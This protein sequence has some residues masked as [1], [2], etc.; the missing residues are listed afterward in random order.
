[1]SHFS[2]YLFQIRSSLQRIITCKNRRRY[3]R[4][5]ASQSSFNFEVMGFNFHRAAPPEV[6]RKARREIF[7]GGSFAPATDLL[8][9][10]LTQLRQQPTQISAGPDE[11][12]WA[13]RARDE[14]AAQ[15][16]RALPQAQEE[17]ERA[18]GAAE[19]EGR[20]MARNRSLQPGTA[21]PSHT[22]TAVDPQQLQPERYL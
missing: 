6:L 5:R 3:S 21:N 1:M 15:L 7:L 8:P 2:Q 10:L 19:R 22:V 12:V 13:R 18:R 4:E 9:H 14:R 20:S 16:L 11:P 17:E